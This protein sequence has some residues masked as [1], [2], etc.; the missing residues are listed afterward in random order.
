MGQLIATIFL[1]N[2]NVKTFLFGHGYGYV[3]YF[4]ENG[5]KNALT[6]EFEGELLSS[7]LSYRIPQVGWNSSLWALLCHI[8]AV[9]APVQ[10]QTGSAAS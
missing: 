10:R 1:I 4:L 8:R 2:L 7:L 6:G 9:S 5:E 3:A